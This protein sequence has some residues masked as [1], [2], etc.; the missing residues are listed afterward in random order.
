MDYNFKTLKGSFTMTRPRKTYQLG[1]ALVGCALL[2]PAYSAPDD[3][4]LRAEPTTGYN[5]S[6]LTGEVSYDL[7][8]ST[9]DIFNLRQSQG[10]VSANAGDYQG[11]HATLNY[12]FSSAISGSASYWRRN[13]DYGQ[14]T[15]SIN[16]WSLGLNYDPFAWDN[17][18][19]RAVFRFSLWGDT[20]NK[21]NKSSPTIVNGTTFNQLSVNNPQDLQA[22]IDAI[23]STKI[24]QANQLTFFVS[25]GLSKVSVDEINTSL[26]RGNCNF[27][28]N[29]NSNNIANGNLASPCAVGTNQLQSATFSSNASDFGVDIKKDLNY[30]AQFIGFGGSWRWTYDKFTS[31][32]GYQF[33]YINRSDVDSRI[34]A[35]GGSPLKTNQTV[36]LDLSYKINDQLAIFFR[37]QAFQYNFVGT[38]PLLYNSQTANKLDRFY[39]YSSLGLRLAAF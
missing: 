25:G 6:H 29:I 39:G 4:F 7:V 32:L 8:N 22:Q 24:N 35:S 34:S 12:K 10:A 1:L 18:T 33:Q 26:R 5:N 23:F 20:A 13:I 37:N 2:H 21:L 36:G 15:N 27:N 3:E 19:D 9:T 31:D 17:A 16:S 14:D 38:I 30:T 11:G 28:V